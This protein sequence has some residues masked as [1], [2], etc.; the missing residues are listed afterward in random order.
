MGE[1]VRWGVLGCARIAVEKVI[2]GM[3][4]CRKA[5]VVAIASR[6]LARA[7]GV[8]RSLGIPRAYGS[9]QEL[10]EEGDV[11]AVYNPLPNHLHVP[12]SVRALQVGKHVLCEKPIAL[13]TEEVRD[14]LAVRDRTGRVVGEAFMVRTHPQWLG[15]RELVRSGRIGRLRAVQGYFSYDNRDPQNIRNVPAYGGGG[16]LDIGCYPVTT[17]RFMFGE[18]PKQV[19][20]LME[21][22]PEMGIDRLTSAL[23]DFPSG[24]ASFLCGTQLVGSQRMH[25]FGTRARIEIEIPFNAPPDRPCRIFVSEGD[26]PDSPLEMLSFPVCDQYALQADLFSEAVLDSRE[27]PVPLE[28]SLK[29]LA[30]LEALFRSAETGSWEAPAL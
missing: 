30:V 10:L 18:E 1:K 28:D 24:Q 3:R 4:K 2:P 11:E 9:Y 7:E 26:R 20:A 6:D 13:S 8:A 25:F 16:L 12:W 22:D 27:P 15:A 23:L 5:E 19:L 17:S 14:L 29:N 21:R